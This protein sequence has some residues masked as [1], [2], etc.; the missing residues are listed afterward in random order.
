MRAHRPGTAIT[1]MRR[2]YRHSIAIAPGRHDFG[3]C[4]CVDAMRGMHELRRPMPMRG[5]VHFGIVRASIDARS[6]RTRQ[7]TAVDRR[8]RPTAIR[9]RTI[10]SNAAPAISARPS[11]R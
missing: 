9:K 2:T 3:Q 7:C 6:G 4:M 11:A 10:D 1:P 8:Q 5:I